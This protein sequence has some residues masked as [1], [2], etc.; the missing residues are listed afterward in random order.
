MLAP[1]QFTEHIIQVQERHKDLNELKPWEQI[2][3][4]IDLVVV[5]C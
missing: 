1:S 3:Y 4:Q 5:L 2:T